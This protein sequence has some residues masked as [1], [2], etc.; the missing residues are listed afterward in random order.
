MSAR[1]CAARL[2]FGDGREGVTDDAMGAARMT[3]EQF[4]VGL[5]GIADMW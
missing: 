1:F 5:V 4:R 2:A 3:F